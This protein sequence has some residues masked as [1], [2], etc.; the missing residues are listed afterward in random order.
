MPWLDLV[1]L[2]GVLVA[3]M[4]NDKSS[5]ASRCVLSV[6]DRVSYKGALWGIEDCHEGV[7][8]STRIYTYKDRKVVWRY[9]FA[10]EL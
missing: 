6:R 8:W 4:I 10:D 2:D 5:G 1:Y 3:G 9:G 7:R